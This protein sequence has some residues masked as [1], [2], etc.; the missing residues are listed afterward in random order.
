M[1]GRPPELYPPC[2]PLQRRLGWA[3]TTKPP[4]YNIAIVEW[5]ILDIRYDR[6]T[7]HT[8]C[9]KR[10]MSMPC[11]AQPNAKRRNLGNTSTV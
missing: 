3:M 5:R 8:L 9:L 2:D 4:W 7:K 6:E 11:V 10:Q 1:I